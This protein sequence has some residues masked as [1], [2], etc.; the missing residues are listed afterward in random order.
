MVKK[1]FVI[2]INMFPG[3]AKMLK[4]FIASLEHNICLRS[5]GVSDYFNITVTNLFD[6]HETISEN[7][8]YFTLEKR[9]FNKIPDYF[10]PSNLM[11]FIAYNKNP[12]DVVS[13]INEQALTIPYWQITNN[14]ILQQFITKDFTDENGEIF[15]KLNAVGRERLGKKVKTEEL[16]EYIEKI[17]DDYPDGNYFQTTFI[18][19]QPRHFDMSEYEEYRFWVHNH[20]PI[21]MTP[22][23]TDEMS[24]STPLVTID[25]ANDFIDMMKRE[26]EMNSSYTFDIIENNVISMRPF[27][28]T[29]INDCLNEDNIYNI[30]SALAEMF[31]EWW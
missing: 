19:S 5:P 16:S 11:G 26:N 23:N 2:D 28:N 30:T 8:F 22:L 7:E 6:K 3:K 4:S 14:E 1:K 29:E 21:A 12:Y 25:A 17:V 9:M 18:I 15:V 13:G 31:V 10:L 20:V 27:I 24:E